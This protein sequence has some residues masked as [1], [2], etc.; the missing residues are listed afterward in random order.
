MLRRCVMALGAAG[1]SAA[2]GLRGHVEMDAHVGCVDASDPDAVSEATRHLERDGAVVVRCQHG[3]TA[4]LV[5][6]MASLLATASSSGRV[7]DAKYVVSSAGR[8]HMAMLGT[9]LEGE[10]VACQ[11]NAWWLPLVGSAPQSPPPDNDQPT[12]VAGPAVNLTTDDNHVSTIDTDVD[13]DVNMPC[14]RRET[15]DQPPRVLSLAQLLDSRPSPSQHQIW[16]ADNVAGGY[17]VV[18]ALCNV[19]LTNGPTACLLGS[20]RLVMEPS[21]QAVWQWWSRPVR[22]ARPQLQRGDVLVYSSALLHRGEANRSDASRP[23][24]VYRYDRANSPVAGV[25]VLGTQ[26]RAM[27]TWCRMYGT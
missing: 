26:L 19:T 14:D 3:E 9:A 18:T 1:G 12:S 17:T 4:T 21:L 7:H 10:A 15:H 8:H 13:V 2:V 11:E 20:H 16:H 22:I 24:V 27:G 25:R 6:R 23:V 5:E